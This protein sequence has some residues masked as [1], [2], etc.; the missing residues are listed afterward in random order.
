M[1]SQIVC[2]GDALIDTFLSIHDA[3]KYCRIDHEHMEICFEAGAKIMVDDAQFQLGG[4]AC[5]VSVGLSRL[6]FATALAAEIGTDEF[7]EK[8]IKGLQKDNV[9]LDLVQQT[10]DAPST[11]SVCLNFKKERTLFVRHVTRKHA[12]DLEKITPDWIYL[13]SLGNEWEALYKKAQEYMQKTG[14]KVAFNP[15]S[16]QLLAGREHFKDILLII[17]SAF[18]QR[19]KVLRNALKLFIEEKTG[20]K[21]DEIVKFAVDSNLDYFSK[22]AEELTKSDFIK[23]N[24]LIN[25]FSKHEEIDKRTAITNKF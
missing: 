6:G 21:I 5:N 15:G 11:F 4:N 1:T 23:L 25:D 24:V 17:K 7:S 18:N 8:I 9:S 19:R 10:P 12:L 20:K 22:R 16:T 13:T 2:I 14:A 3:A